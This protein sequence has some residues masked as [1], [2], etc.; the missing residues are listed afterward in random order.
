MNGYIRADKQQQNRYSKVHGRKRMLLSQCKHIINEGSSGWLLLAEL[1]DSC[2]ELRTDNE[3]WE[4]VD[5]GGVDL[6]AHP[7][8]EDRAR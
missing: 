7:L 8:C 3:I 2:L 1:A 5:C 6:G 4:V